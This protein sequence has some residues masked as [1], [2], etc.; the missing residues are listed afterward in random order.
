MSKPTSFL[1]SRR[2]ATVCLVLAA[3]YFL[4]MR[5]WQHV[6]A[7]APYLI[8]LACPLMHVF[9]HGGHGRHAGHHGGDTED[10]AY[11]RGLEEGKKQK[12]V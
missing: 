1:T 12:S 3:G 11:R 6:L 8:L 9:M 5:H 7:F 10:A 4:V 2:M